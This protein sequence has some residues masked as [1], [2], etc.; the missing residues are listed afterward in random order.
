MSYRALNGSFELVN[1]NMRYNSSMIVFKD[2]ELVRD[3]LSFRVEF[4]KF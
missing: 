2:F 3:F 4:N 1:W